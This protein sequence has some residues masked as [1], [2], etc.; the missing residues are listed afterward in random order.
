MWQ[1]RQLEL[2]LIGHAEPCRT[3][4]GFASLLFD[5]VAEAEAEG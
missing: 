1:P 3:A 5:G 2:A 4:G